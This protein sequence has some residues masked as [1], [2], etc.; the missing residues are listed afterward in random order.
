MSGALPGTGPES[1]GPPCAGGPIGAV[2]RSGTV[3]GEG[4]SQ[5]AISLRRARSHQR[6]HPLGRQDFEPPLA[7]QDVTENCRRSTEQ[8]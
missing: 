7:E 6:S 1:A 3:K 2:T 8:Y 5:L 4:G